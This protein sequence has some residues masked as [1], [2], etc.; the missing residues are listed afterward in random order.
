MM[1]RMMRRKEVLSVTGLSGS[2]QYREEKAGRFPSRMK[3][4]SGTV[5]WN[6][7]EI[8]DWLSNRKKVTS[9]AKDF[10]SSQKGRQNENINRTIQ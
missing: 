9:S 10:S 1:S 5:G 6:R 2:T 7:D 4:S 8:S 3:L